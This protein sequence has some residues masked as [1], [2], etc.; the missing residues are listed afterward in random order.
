L[1]SKNQ[2]VIL[3]VVAGEESGAT[4][5]EF[6]RI[7]DKYDTIRIF[8]QRNNGEE[9]IVVNKIWLFPEVK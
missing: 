2:A 7:S 9:E 3:R 1:A 6:K 8:A 4:H 5:E